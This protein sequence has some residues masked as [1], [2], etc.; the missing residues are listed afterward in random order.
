M[1]IPLA[2]EYF[3]LRGVALLIDTVDKVQD[4]LN[5]ELKISGI[6]VTMF[7]PRTVHAREVWHRVIEGFGDLV[8]DTVITRTVRFPETTVAGE[9]ITT[10]APKSN[11][12]QAYRLLAREVIAPVRRRGHAES[13]PRTSPPTASRSGCTTS[14]ARSTCCCS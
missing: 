2:C 13:Q 9:P 8:F 6:L 14:R 3:S 5:P 7:D 1:I 12:A 10:W 11:G 4:R